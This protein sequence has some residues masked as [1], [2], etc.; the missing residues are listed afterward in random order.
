[1][2]RKQVVLVHCRRHFYVHILKNE[3]ERLCEY[4]SLSTW[5]NK[6]INVNGNRQGEEV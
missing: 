4:L 3:C 2:A 6:H 1:M 5:L